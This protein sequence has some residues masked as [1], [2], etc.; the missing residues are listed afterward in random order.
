[1]GL[2][3]LNILD[4]FRSFLEFAEVDQIARQSVFTAVLYKRESGQEY[5]WKRIKQ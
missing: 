2:P 3:A 4:D 5:A 1:M